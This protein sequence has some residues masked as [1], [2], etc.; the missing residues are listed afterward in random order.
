MYTTGFSPRKIK[1]QPVGTE[2][3]GSPGRSKDSEDSD[4]FL[5]KVKILKM[6]QKIVAIQEKSESK[7][8]QEKNPRIVPRKPKYNEDSQEKNLKK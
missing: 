2:K 4:D 8:S 6:I 7:E 5:R 1:K 3:T